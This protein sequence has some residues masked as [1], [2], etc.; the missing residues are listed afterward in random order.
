MCSLKNK[1]N[2]LSNLG[3]NTLIASTNSTDTNIS[4]LLNKSFFSSILKLCVIPLDDQTASARA[5]V[6]PKRMRLAEEARFRHAA[7]REI[8]DAWTTGDVR[9]RPSNAFAARTCLYYILQHVGYDVGSCYHSKK[10]HP[11]LS[12]S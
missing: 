9:E 7:F 10:I 2:H 5:R 12:L 11:G 6:F 8:S 4:A 1:E 3:E